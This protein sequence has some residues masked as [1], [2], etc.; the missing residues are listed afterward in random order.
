MQIS[1]IPWKALAAVN[2]WMWCNPFFLKGWPPA[3]KGMKDL[4]AKC[5]RD[6]RLCL[7]EEGKLREENEK[8]K[9]D[10]KQLPGQ[11]QNLTEQC[12]KQ[13]TVM[14]ALKWELEKSLQCYEE[15]RTELHAT[16]VQNDT[17]LVQIQ[18]HY[19]LIEELKK[20][21]AELENT[22]EKNESCCH[23][24]GLHLA[25]AYCWVLERYGAETQDFKVN[26]NIATYYLWMNSE[27]KLLPDTMSNIGDYGVVTSSEAIFHLLEERGCEHFKAFGTHG[28]EFPSSDTMPTP[29]KTVDAI[30][31]I[32]LRNF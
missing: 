25:Q 28:F 17:H 29:S 27:L 22:L 3:A 12:S 26:D 15:C 14:D 31:K 13:Q 10:S 9:N 11:V 32:V 19:A 23:Q 20:V 8:L 5:S 30:T 2:Y 24:W 16:V 1:S 7:E 18:T 21:T 6:E 4:Q